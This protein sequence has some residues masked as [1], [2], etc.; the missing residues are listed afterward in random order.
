MRGERMS[1][2]RLAT[3]PPPPPYKGDCFSLMSV[4]DCF[5][6]MSVGELIKVKTEKGKRKGFLSTP[7]GASLLV[8]PVSGG[9]FW[10]R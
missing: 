9:Q 4:G 3:Y 1:G 10:K 6:L 7:S 2:E 8:A 5:S